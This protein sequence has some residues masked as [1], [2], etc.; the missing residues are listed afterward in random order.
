[1]TAGAKPAV[2]F[3]LSQPVA[4]AVANSTWPFCRASV[5]IAS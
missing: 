4:I 2:L 5:A 1:M 3:H